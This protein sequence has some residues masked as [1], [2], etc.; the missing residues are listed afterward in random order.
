LYL[1]A[2]LNKSR[3]TIPDRMS[4]G[5]DGKVQTVDSSMREFAKDAGI[6]YFSP[7]TILCD[8]NGCLT[9]V[10]D[11]PDKITAWDT[12]HLTIAASHYV[13]SHFTE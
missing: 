5:L 10:G 1:Y 3:L 7:Y 13:V 6:N 4:Y 8:P 2:R 11:T 12:A 9:M